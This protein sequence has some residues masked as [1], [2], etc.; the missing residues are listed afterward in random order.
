MDAQD[1][2]NTSKEGKSINPQHDRLIGLSDSLTYLPLIYGLK[3]Q[4]I[5]HDF[6]VRFG[7]LFENAIKLR[8][9]EIEIG[10]ISS[11]DYALKKETWQIVPDLCISSPR[12][13][14]DVQLF[15]KKGLKDIRTVAVDK[16]AASEITLLK[17]L[18]R[19]KF[20]ISPDYIEREPDLDRMLLDAEAALIVGDQALNYYTVNPNRLDLNDEWMDLT[21]LPMVY[22][23]WAGREIT[24]TPDD[25]KILHTSFNLGSNNLE[26]ISKDYAS[27]H[28]E[29][30]VFYHDFLTQNISYSFSDLE[31]EGLNEF[32]NYAF[33]YG[34]TEF[35]P[36]LH[37]YKL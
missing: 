29:N 37:F 19:E 4:L 25:I 26:K 32:Y 3:H 27:K 35:V 11:L 6:L 23:F 34:F 21:G 18:M 16:N 36:D 22:A 12:K 2:F 20:L 24:V 30:W 9:G 17:I 31:K 14:K 13:I 5:H 8:E 15:F 10:L 1:L 33:F 28:Q 7:S